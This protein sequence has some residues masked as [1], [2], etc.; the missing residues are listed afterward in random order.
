[1]R[2]DD[3]GTI[4]A[5]ASGG[6]RSAITVIRVSGQDCAAI[7]GRLCRSLPPPRTASLRTI[8]DA[9]GGALDRGIVLWFPGPHSYTGEDAAEL[10]LHG[11]RAVADA[12]VTALSAAGARPAHPGEFTRRSFLNGQLGLIEAEAVGDLIDA[13]TEAQRS[14]AV[15]QLQGRLG[16]LYREWADRLLRVTSHQEALIDFPDE[17]L[18]AAVDAAIGAEI[19]DLHRE[20]SAHLADGHRGERIRD[21][22]VIAIAGPP[23]VG[24]SSLMNAIARRDVAI[25]SPTAGTTRDV[26]Q[27]RIVLAGVPVT[28]VDTAGLRETENAIEKIGVE[29]GQKRAGEADIVVALGSVEGAE[30]RVP[31][32]SGF[33][34]VVCN[35]IDLAPAPDWS[36]IAVSASTGEGVSLLLDRLGSIVADLT[37]SSEAPALTRARHR[38]ALEQAGAAL[39]RAAKPALPELRGE[40]LRTALFAFGTLLGRIGVEDVLDQIFGEFCIGK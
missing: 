20:I 36:D 29:W 30:P 4:Y 33:V 1:M 5:I 39:G 23:N 32:A 27:E 2:P 12:V 25:V 34:L 35:K 18:P 37:R 40:D 13:E 15:R 9:S 6:H 11:G 17:D 3:D 16:G 38:V 10:Q 26:L 7:V 28:L 22:I 31:S 21:G 24:K 14:Q 19:A 8:R